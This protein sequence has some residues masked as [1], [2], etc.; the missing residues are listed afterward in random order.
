MEWE[1]G[2][3]VIFMKSRGVKYGGQAGKEKFQ[4]KRSSKGKVDV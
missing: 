2:F 3:H 1:K 4:K